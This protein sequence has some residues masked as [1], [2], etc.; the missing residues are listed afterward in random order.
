[1]T[2]YTQEPFRLGRVIGRSLS[3]W[4]RTLA[5]LFTLVLVVSAPRIAF[6]IYLVLAPPDPVPVP[7][8]LSSPFGW[9]LP[10]LPL[11]LGM[12]L[13]RTLF[14]NL[15]QAVVIFA[16]Y[17]RM[18]GGAA[19]FGES[20][21]GGLRRAWPVLCVAV[22]LFLLDSA[23]LLALL[24]VVL[25]LP[26][27]ATK[28]A[29]YA[30]PLIRLLALSPFWVAVP[31][32]VVERSRGFLRR[33]WILTSG[34]RLRVFLILV[35]VYALE[36]GAGRLCVLVVPDRPRVAQAVLWWAQD[37]LLVALAAAVAVVGYH[38]LRLEKDGVDTAELAEVFA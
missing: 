31:A 20:V 28:Y 19:A 24:S 36:W 2:D 13:V 21:R 7:D 6:E 30:I 15:S 38:A 27:A 18:R 34:H 32:A 3:L 12:G 33:S 26:Y 14:V 10:Y 35:I 22:V 9:L 5:P 37:L 16:V 25:E 11:M 29:F 4:G 8:D 17:Q 1:M 23:I